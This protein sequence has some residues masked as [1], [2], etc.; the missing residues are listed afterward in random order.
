[1]TD[2][3]TPT[4]TAV[5]PTAVA[6]TVAPTTPQ[7]TPKAV[8]DDGDARLADLTKELETA[9]GKL[10]EIEASK[11]EAERK[12]QIEQ[13]D[14]K[15]LLDSD[16]Q[17][18]QDELKAKDE[19]IR[20]YQQTI[21]DQQR[22]SLIKQTAAE[23]M[24]TDWQWLGELMLKDRIGVT[25]D[26]KGKPKTLVYDAE[27][28]KTNLSI[29]KLKEEMVADK[30]IEQFLLGGKVGSGA[31]VAPTDAKTPTFLNQYQQVPQQ[32]P[33]QAFTPM[34]PRQ[35]GIVTADARQVSEWIKAK[36]RAK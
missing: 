11:A 24:L 26:E 5:A 2:A 19:Q 25:L 30:R 12:R 35:Q 8:Q 4:P 29:D 10:A 18:Y 27:R 23:L 20:A 6:P 21:A 22:D 14:L 9:R 32:Q 1:M 36:R 28:N 15:K 17:K 31:N 34:Q 13:G 7:V 3:V 16:Q 33:Q